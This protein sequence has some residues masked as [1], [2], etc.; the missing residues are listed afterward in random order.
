VVQN[1]PTGTLIRLLLIV[2]LLSLGAC[3][4]RPSVGITISNTPES[5]ENCGKK[6]GP[7]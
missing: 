2:V 1:S 4:E 6:I 7:C 3:A 5:I